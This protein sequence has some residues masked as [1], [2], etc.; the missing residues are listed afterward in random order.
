MP[1]T[2]AS[3]QGKIPLCVDL[4]GSLVNTD[5]LVESIL[6]LLKQNTFLII[7]MFYWLLS[8]KANLKEQI[9]ARTALDVTAL[10]YNQPLLDWL[11]SQRAAGRSLIL[12]TAAS[13]RIAGPIGDHLQMFTRVIA[14]TPDN[15]LSAANKRDELDKQFGKGHSRQIRLRHQQP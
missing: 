9:A 13:G 12:V 11:R 3:E 6:Q 5:T 15:N 2:A 8:G 4:D 10:P 7:A 14:S 1:T